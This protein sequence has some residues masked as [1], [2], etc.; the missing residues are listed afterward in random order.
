MARPKTGGGGGRAA[1]PGQDRET[2]ISKAASWLLRHGAVREG[3]RV[4][5]AGWVN[6]GDLVCGGFFWGGGGGLGPSF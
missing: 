1:R 3:V 6:V 2:A 5:E 4:D